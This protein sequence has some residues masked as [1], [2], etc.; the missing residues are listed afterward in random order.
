MTILESAACS[1]PT[2]AS[3]IYGITDAVEEGKTGVLFTAGDIAGLTQSL[4]KLIDNVHLRQEMGIVAKQRVLEL[5][6]SYKVTEGIMAFYN[7]L[8]AD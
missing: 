7:E 6:P 8:L 4:L 3:R 1:V 2:V 5:F